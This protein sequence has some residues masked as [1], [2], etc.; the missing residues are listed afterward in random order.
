M[1]N[2][3][4]FNCLP[5]TQKQDSIHRIEIYLQCTDAQAMLDFKFKQTKGMVGT[6]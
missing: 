1:S 4:L 3:F 5:E 2:N 6:P